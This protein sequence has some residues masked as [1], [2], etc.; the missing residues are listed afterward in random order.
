[1]FF[2]PDKKGPVRRMKNKATN[3]EKI[4]VNPIAEK[5]LTD[6]VLKSPEPL[7]QSPPIVTFYIMY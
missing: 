7:T 6:L 2:F 1:M 3:W 5:K 4:L